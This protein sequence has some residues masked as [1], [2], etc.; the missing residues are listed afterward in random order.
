M[1]TTEVHLAKDFEG[2]I[3]SARAFLYASSITLPRSLDSKGSMKF[4][5]D[6]ER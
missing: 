2:T 5:T 6:F 4:E 3:D 1:Q